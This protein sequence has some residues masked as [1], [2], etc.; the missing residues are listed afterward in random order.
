MKGKN[1]TLFIIGVLL[2]SVSFI[3]KRYIALT[4]IMDGFIKGVAFGLMILSLV[5]TLK[6]RKQEIQLK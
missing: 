4:D 2:M 6:K 5:F 1:L 3:L